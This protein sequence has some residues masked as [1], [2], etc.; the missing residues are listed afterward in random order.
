[1]GQKLYYNQTFMDRK[2]KQNSELEIK[3][4]ALNEIV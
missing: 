4:N 3:L 1:M 2:F